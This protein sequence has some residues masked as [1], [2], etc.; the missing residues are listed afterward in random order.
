MDLEGSRHVN[1]PV[2]GLT[3][4]VLFERPNLQERVLAVNLLEQVP[5][6]HQ[7]GRIPDHTER[8]YK[9]SKAW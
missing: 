6:F 5:A 9:S 3:H 1:Q 8:V 4:P 2:T 7:A